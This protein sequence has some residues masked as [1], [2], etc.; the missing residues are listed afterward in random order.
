MRDDERGLRDRHHIVT[1]LGNVRPS[2]QKDYEAARYDFADGEPPVEEKL[3]GLA[4]LNRLRRRVPATSFSLIILGTAGSMWDMLLEYARGPTHLTEPADLEQYVRLYDLADAGRIGEEDVR[5]LEADLAARLGCPCQLVV[6]PYGTSTRE[7]VDILHQLATRI[8]PGETVSFDVTH[9]FRHLPLIGLMAALYLRGAQRVTIEG[10]YYGAWMMKRDGVAPVLSLDGVMELVDW[11]AAL[12]A[13]DRDGDLGTFV[14]LL[15][16]DG[17]GE[18]LVRLLGRTAF[19]ERLFHAETAR[20][21]GR[22]FL[23]KLDPLRLH[24][25]GKL[26]AE[27]LADRLA[28]SAEAQLWLSQRRLAAD[29]LAREDFLRAA[30]YA[31][32]AF[33]SRMVEWREDAGGGATDDMRRQTYDRREAAVAAYRDFMESG[34]ARRVLVSD[35]AAARRRYETFLRLNDLRNALAHG[36][37]PRR[38][39]VERT[40]ESAENTAAFLRKVLAELLDPA[41]PFP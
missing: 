5:P 33:V 1:F 20:D 40:L 37:P 2:L 30:I 26:F 7:Q 35:I 14:P 23:A 29:Y 28:W 32:E 10:L 4:L 19:Y 13:F 24:G 15:A 36:T 39:E 25:T 16:R 34:Q 11:V 31:L 18:N 38:R 41:V 8:G 17:A 22:D 27:S 12:H 9:G 3:F 21:L 6:I